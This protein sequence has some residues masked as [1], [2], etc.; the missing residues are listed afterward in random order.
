MNLEEDAKRL[1]DLYPDLAKLCQEHDML[2]T[3]KAALKGAA[4]M[5]FIEGNVKGYDDLVRTLWIESGNE[6]REHMNLE[7]DGFSF[8]VSPRFV[9]ETF[10]N[11]I[12]GGNFD[13]NSGRTT[14]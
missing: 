12:I 11:E 14:S 4:R 13:A 6:R 5:G 3:L 10:L 9:V 1:I 2:D 8:D 7:T